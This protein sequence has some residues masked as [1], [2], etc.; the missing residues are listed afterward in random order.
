M[1]LPAYGTTSP[2]PSIATLLNTQHITNHSLLDFFFLPG[3]APSATKRNRSRSPGGTSSPPSTSALLDPL[4]YS[5][6]LA[7][8]TLPPGAMRCRDL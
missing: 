5:H 4:C 8:H 2:D 1:N 6:R 3:A 7:G